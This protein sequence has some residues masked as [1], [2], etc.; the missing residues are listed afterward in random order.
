MSRAFVIR[1]FGGKTLSSGLAIDFDRV[2]GELVGPALVANGLAGGTTEVIDESGGIREDMFGLILEA[3]LVVCDISMSNPNVYYEL[4]VRHALRKHGTVLIKAKA[5]E[6]A[7]GKAKGTADATPFDILTERYLSYDSTDPAATRAR[8]VDVIRATLATERETDSPVF[9]MLPKLPEPDRATIG[10]VPVG[11]AE[12]I[13]RAKAARMPGWLRLLASDVEGLRFEW[14]ALRLIAEALFDLKDYE[15][16]LSAWEKVRARD[17]D[18]LQANFALANIHERRY[19]DSRDEADFTESEQAADRVLRNPLAQVKDRVEALSLKGRNIKTRWRLSFESLPDDQRRAAAINGTLLD[20]WG[21]YHQA[22]QLDLNHYWSGLAALQMAALIVDFAGE[23]SFANLFDTPE[24]MKTFL[25][26]LRREVEPLRACV[27]KAVQAATARV[28]MDPAD[29]VWGL[30]SVADLLFLREDLPKEKIAKRYCD[31]LSK[32]TAFAWDAARGQLE[33][34]A[35]AGLRKDVA[36]HVIAAVNA[37][38]GEAPAGLKQHVVVFAGHRID[39]AGR[40]QPRFPATK[41]AEDLARNLI[42]EQIAAL[43]EPGVALRVL[44]SGAPGADILCLEVCDELK[45]DCTVC[46]PMPQDEYSNKVFETLDEWRNRFLASMSTRRP[47]F[48]S[49]RNGLPD[50]LVTKNVSPWERGNRWMLEMAGS[51]GTKRLTLLVLWDGT[52][53]G[54]APGGTAHMVQLARAAG[55]FKI[56]PI[57]AKLLLEAR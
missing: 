42:R 26:E 8:L 22:Y 43:R 27:M 57:D 44:L 48:L 30:I 35:K 28:D 25:D 39:E 37:K 53:A 16:S 7:P 17:R 1:P 38:L 4:G 54:D 10:V 19:R 52:M 14:P 32:S 3:D 51:S 12:E 56:A 29:K 13:E 50:W 49:N 21:A 55:N 36:A 2:H 33:L 23:P 40:A 46:L 31:A 9:K 18:G 45:V 41:D 47:I 15:A 20:A 24:E 34:F 11:L 5:T 6:A